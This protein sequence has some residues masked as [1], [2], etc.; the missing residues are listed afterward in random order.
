MADVERHV[1]TLLGDILGFS[2]GRKEGKADSWNVADMGAWLRSY[3]VAK[4]ELETRLNI[5]TT[6][7]LRKTAEG[8]DLFIS[9]SDSLDTWIK[10]TSPY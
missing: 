4:E 3:F 9:M 10:S 1:T 2:S 5:L 6:T 7:L 8:M